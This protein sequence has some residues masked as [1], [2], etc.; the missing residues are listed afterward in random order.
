MPNKHCVYFKPNISRQT[1]MRKRN[2]LK[3][4]MSDARIHGL[5]NRLVMT[6]ARF[7]EATDI[8]M[9]QGISLPLKLEVVQTTIK[10]NHLTATQLDDAASIFNKQKLYSSLK[11]KDINNISDKKYQACRRLL[12]YAAMPGLFSVTRLQKEVDKQHTII[13]TR[14]GAY[15]LPMPKIQNV[16]EEYM[17]RN[18]AHTGPFVIKLSM[19]GTSITGSSHLQVLNSTFTVIHCE[20]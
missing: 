14:F 10:P 20:M 4:L 16:C 3:A 11:F 9:Q 15:T 19:D 2:Q 8:D 1:Q 18:P 6:A 12:G 13:R 5:K 17:R 7:E